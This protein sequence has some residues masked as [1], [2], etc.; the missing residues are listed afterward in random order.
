M[1]RLLFPFLCFC[2]SL[3]TFFVVAHSKGVSECTHHV[4]SSF[5]PYIPF[6]NEFLS[7]EDVK[8][9]LNPGDVV[10]F[11]S[12]EYSSVHLKGVNGTKLKPIVLKSITE[13]EA[14]IELS[15][16]KGTGIGIRESSFVVIEGFMISGGLYGI[17]SVDSHDLFIRNN[18][19]ESV[20]QEGILLTVD[21]C[22]SSS[23]NYLI[24]KNKILSTGRKNSQYG[25]GIYV[26]SG[27]ESNCGVKNVAIEGNSIS[28]TTNEAID[29]KYNV[30]DVLIKNNDISD[31]DLA[32]NGVITLSTSDFPKVDGRYQVISNRISNFSNRNGYKA[33]AVAVGNGSALISGNVV[34]NKDGLFVKYYKSLLSNSFDRVV[35]E[36]NSLSGGITYSNICC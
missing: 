19:I 5:F 16:F 23:E 21:R 29:I 25:E 15:D 26:G 7:F 10:C 24:A 11:E 4:S 14:H 12:G 36:S 13:R 34:I 8:E 31:V 9:S 28:H 32:F 2:V 6:L 17:R 35:I 30:S 27:K 20:G 3:S 22:R 18:W 33:V 1:K